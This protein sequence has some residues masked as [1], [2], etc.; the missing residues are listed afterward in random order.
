M[1]MHTIGVS[2]AL[3]VD[4]ATVELGGIRILDKVSFTVNQGILVGVVGPD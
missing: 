2:P 3:V 1:S 4:N